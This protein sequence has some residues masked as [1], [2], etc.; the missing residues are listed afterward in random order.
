MK[1]VSLVVVLAAVA[2]VAYG[3]PEPGLRFKIGRI[4]GTMNG[5]MTGSYEPSLLFSTLDFSF[6]KGHRFAG[7]IKLQAGRSKIN[8]L[9]STPGPTAAMAGIMVKIG[10]VYAQT[11]GG[12]SDDGLVFEEDIRGSLNKKFFFKRF[13]LELIGRHASS[14][15]R[16]WTRTR[17]SVLV[18]KGKLT[19]FSIGGEHVYSAWDAGKYYVTRQGLVI[20]IDLFHR[21]RILA[22]GG[23]AEEAESQGY[24]FLEISNRLF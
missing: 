21:T 4:K 10:S 3:D 17:P 19:E 14:N 18:R 5:Y 6:P 1:K 13:D 15:C 22:G 23:R 16:F 11:F 20:G 12:Y 7:L 9:T 2:T 24:F 8:D